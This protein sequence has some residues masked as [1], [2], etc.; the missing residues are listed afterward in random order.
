MMIATTAAAPKGKLPRRFSL[1]GQLASFGK[2][3][4]TKRRAS[5]ATVP[6][7]PPVPTSVED[8]SQVDLHCEPRATCGATPL[9]ARCIREEKWTEAYAIRV[10]K[11]YIQWLTLLKLGAEKE[12]EEEWGAAPPPSAIEKLWRQHILDGTNYYGDCQLLCGRVVH[13]NPDANLLPPPETEE[14][15]QE[16]AFIRERRTQFTRELLLLN[17][18]LAEIDVEIWKEVLLP[19][20][21]GEPQEEGKENE[22]NAPKKT[23][24][25]IKSGSSSKKKNKKKPQQQPQPQ[26]QNRKKYIQIFVKPPAGGTPL[27][28]C[29]STEYTVEMLKIM[30][31]ERMSRDVQIPADKH[32]LK[33]E[34]QYLDENKKL[35]Y[36]GIDCENTLL[37]CRVS[38]V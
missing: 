5:I 2:K 28:F 30:L 11:A 21:V 18:P 34:G 26:Q 6:P 19:S 12:E 35:S 25:G 14:E 1:V 8:W 7:P 24:A 23:A 22:E 38:T 15:E 4:K 32:E 10:L 16:E 9:V 37:C 29:V 20:I 3:K 17:F 33:F 36:Y 13:H 31:E 27:T